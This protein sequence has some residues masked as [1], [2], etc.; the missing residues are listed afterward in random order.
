MGII[1]T[2]LFCFGL[3]EAVTMTLSFIGV[4]I[5]DYIIP[6]VCVC[7]DTSD[8]AEKKKSQK[9]TRVRVE[10]VPGTRAPETPPGS[11]GPHVHTVYIFPSIC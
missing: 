10:K 3:I 5:N 9:L 8:L 4:W 7:A 1:L 6:C 11:K 2:I